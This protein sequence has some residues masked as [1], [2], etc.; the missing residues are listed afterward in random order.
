MFGLVSAVPLWRLKR[1]GLLLCNL[2]FGFELLYFLGQAFL[3][4]AFIGSSN[5]VL[6]G[7]GS[8]IAGATGIGG[9]GLALQDITAYPIIALIALNVAYHKLRKIETSAVSVAQP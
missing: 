6:K 4:L 1:S 3:A 5:Q 9:L 8:S 2:L 7:L